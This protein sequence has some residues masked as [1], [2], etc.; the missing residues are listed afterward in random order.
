MY[1]ERFKPVVFTANI[2]ISAVYMR[3]RNISFGPTHCTGVLY[4]VAGPE[5]G[6]MS[7]SARGEVPVFTHDA[8][9][10]HRIQQVNHP[11]IM[12]RI[13]H[14]QNGAIDVIMSLVMGNSVL[15]SHF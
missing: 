9:H 11:F 8:C 1:F 12:P 3:S 15:I 10:V 14:S 4:T 5:L 6:A 2:T 7:V 13:C